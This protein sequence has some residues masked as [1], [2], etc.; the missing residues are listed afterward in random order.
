MFYLALKKNKNKE[1]KK[2]FDLFLL[3]VSLISNK[4]K[5]RSRNPENDRNGAESAFNFTAVCSSKDH[6]KS[7][8]QCV[9]SVTRMLCSV[10]FVFKGCT[11]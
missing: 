1:F 6:R 2:Q 10:Y 11:T 9:R 3:T 4:R 7:N 5:Y 8:E